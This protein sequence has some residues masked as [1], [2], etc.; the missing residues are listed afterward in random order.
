MTPLTMFAISPWVAR[1]RN[2]NSRDRT[3]SM[4]ACACVCCMLCMLDVM[5]NSCF[6]RLS[7]FHEDLHTFASNWSNRPEVGCHRSFPI[8]ARALYLP[9]SAR[10]CRKT[11]RWDYFPAVGHLCYPAS[12][13]QPNCS[14]HIIVSVFVVVTY[15]VSWIVAC[16]LMQSLAMW[17]FHL[18]N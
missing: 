9:Y 15:F 1:S 5:S 3:Y 18:T 11:M 12:G 4:S 16:L 2:G 6:S 17:W 13:I 7:D 10:C 8:G 14:K